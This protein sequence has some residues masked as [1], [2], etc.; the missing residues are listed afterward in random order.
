MVVYQRRRGFALGCSVLACA[1]GLAGCSS[2]G[3]GADGD[4]RT[5]VIGVTGDTFTL[6]PQ[7]CAP[8]V[9]CAPAY[10]ALIDQKPDGTFAPDLATKWDFTSAEHTTV[11]LALRDD[12][13]FD[14]GAPLTADAVVASL[15]TFRTT[16]GPGQANAQPVDDV[17]AVDERTVDIHYSAPVTLDYAAWQLTAQNGFGAIVG[18]KGIADIS[19]LDT[20]SD[21]IGPYKLDPAQTTKGAQYTYV[22]NDQYFNQAA[23]KYD[24]VVLKPMQNSASRLSAIKSGQIDWAQGIPEGDVDGAE[25]AG[26]RIS[27]GKLGAAP[28]GMP[29]LVLAGRGSGPL[30][31]VRV[32]QAISYAVPR[33]DIAPAL[34][35]STATPVSSLVPEG[36]EGYDAAQTTRYDHDP[37]KAKD[38]LTQAGYPDGFDLEVYSPSFFDPGNALGQAL[39]SALGNVGIR[40]NLVASDAPPGDVVQEVGTMKHAAYI[41]NAGAVGTMSLAYVNFQQG[42]YMNPFKM[43]SDPQLDALLKDATLAATPAEANERMK[44]ATA[45]MDELEWAVPVA[46][47]PT[48]QATREDV[49]NVPDTF[50]SRELNPFSPVTD[51]NWHSGTTAGGSEG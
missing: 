26:L 46:V 43:P 32:R 35:G 31:D 10:G 44:A 22:P 21:G 2:G 25:A 17:K 47:V 33:A 19:S 14:D 8:V 20:A 5:L 29:M 49:Q 36:A 41:W 9:Y 13:R 30:A 4:R 23:I 50:Y 15:N 28:A 12:A 51:E 40:V 7:N 45:R 34:Y 6:N 48:L 1:V 18:A 37:A 42:A 24:K 38:L 11:R 3:D 27:E 39:E 16:P